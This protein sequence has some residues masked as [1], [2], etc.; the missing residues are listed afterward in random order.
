MTK[1]EL[2]KMLTD[3]AHLP[4]DTP[5]LTCDQEWGYNPSR[6]VTEATVRRHDEPYCGQYADTFEEA[7]G[8]RKV[9]VIV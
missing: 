7:K 8:A 9:I 1:D 2:I 5:V 4:G 3:L 6:R